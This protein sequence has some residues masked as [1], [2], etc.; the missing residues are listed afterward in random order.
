MVLAFFDHFL[1]DILEVRVVFVSDQIQIH[2]LCLLVD[3]KR[4]IV[5]DLILASGDLDFFFKVDQVFVVSKPLCIS[6]ALVIVIEVFISI[7]KELLVQSVQVDFLGDLFEVDRLQQLD[8]HWPKVAEHVA[9]FVFFG[10][11]EAIVEAQRA[12]AFV[13]GL[14]GEKICEPKI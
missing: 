14:Q 11:P 10:L 4:H 5:I 9:D 6:R 1:A 7:L 8:N 12:I 3:E 13:H 2:W